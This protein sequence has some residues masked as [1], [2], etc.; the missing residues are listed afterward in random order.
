MVI[1]ECI[2]VLR[3]EEIDMLKQSN[4][5]LRTE[6][7]ATKSTSEMQLEQLHK[8]LHDSEGNKQLASQVKQLE[9]ENKELQESS[10]K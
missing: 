2:N 7:A 3:L 9:Q 8:R 1:S 4:R 10:K 5:D 6:L